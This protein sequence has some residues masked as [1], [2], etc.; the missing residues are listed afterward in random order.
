[1]KSFRVTRSRIIA[2]AIGIP[3]LLAAVGQGVVTA[4]GLFARSSENFTAS[5]AWNGG[6]FTLHGGDGA[7]TVRQGSSPRVEVS[8][9]THFGLKKPTVQAVAGATGLEL[10]AKC[11]ADLYDSYCSVDF[12]VLVP[13]R[14]AL[15]LS[16]GDGHVTLDGVDGDVTVHSGDGRIEGSDLAATR[17]TATAGDGS[18]D[19]QWAVTPQSVRVSTGD[20]SVDLTVPEGS[21]PYAIDHRTGD[22]STTI[23]VSVDPTAP[24]SM[25]LR[26]GD[27][28]LTV[29]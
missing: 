26:T 22:G 28:D 8:Y 12:T 17:L 11:P 10:S 14:T 5:Y 29:N 20:G 13:A 16:T 19:L 18:V 27:G 24:R 9:T 4:T 6:V 25:V 23:G 21:G 3:V 2:V 1:M 15:D 7:V